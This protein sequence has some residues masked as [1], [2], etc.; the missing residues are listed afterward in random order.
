MSWLYAQELAAS[1]SLFGNP[2]ERVSS[3]TWRGKHMPWPYWFI[4]WKKERWLRLLSGLTYETSRLERFEVAWISSLRDS[5][6]NRIASQ[7]SDSAPAT[8]AGCSMIS[9]ASFAR[10]DQ[11]SS[12][13]RTSPALL[14][15]VSTGFLGHWPS[16]GSMRSGGVFRRPKSELPTGGIG[17]SSLLPTPTARD[18]RSGKASQATHERNSRPLSEQVGGL[19]NPRWVEWLMGMP[20]GWTSLEHL[21]TQSCPRKPSTHSESLAGG[22]S[23]D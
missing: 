9:R 4:K 22:C 13:W 15:L 7:A 12:S 16:S 23:H 17:C 3:L 21:E 1:R 8:I 11:A 18:W 20:E 2:S 14:P 19:L 6:A 10:F 5:H